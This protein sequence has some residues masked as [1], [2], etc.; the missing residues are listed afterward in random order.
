LIRDAYGIPRLSLTDYPFRSA[1][2][3]SQYEG[4]KS[5]GMGCAQLIRNLV[6]HGAQ[7]D[8][9]T[10]LEQLASLSLFARLVDRAQK[11]TA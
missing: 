2:W 6:T 4:G 5:F 11:I 9:Q 8:E 1:N 10:A 7:P 3:T